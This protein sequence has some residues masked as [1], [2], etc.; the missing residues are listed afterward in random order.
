MTNED[1]VNFHHNPFMMNLKDT[2]INFMAPFQGWVQL[3]QGYR[4]TKRRTFNSKSLGDAGTHL[5]Y[6]RRMKGQYILSHFY[7]PVGALSL[8]KYFPQFS[9]N[10]ADYVTM[11]GGKFEI[12]GAQIT[13]KWIFDSKKRQ[14]I[15]LLMPSGKTVPQVQIITPTQ[16]Q[17]PLQQK[18]GK[19]YRPQVL[20]KFSPPGPVLD[21][22]NFFTFLNSKNFNTALRLG[23]FILNLT[24]VNKHMSFLVLTIYMPCRSKTCTAHRYFTILNDHQM[25]SEMVAYPISTANF[26][27]YQSS[28]SIP[29][30]I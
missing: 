4:A 11:V 24:Y 23:G 5:I 7:K 18:R 6:L 10:E 21:F 27:K 29:C 17:F 28:Y 19:L 26:I 13:R 25:T 16:I 20:V 15:S 14:Y 1:S 12:H 9:L 30:H 8:F 3:S 22:F 2:Q